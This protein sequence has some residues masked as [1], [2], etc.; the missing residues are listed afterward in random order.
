MRADPPGLAARPGSRRQVFGAALEQWDALFESSKTAPPSTAPILLFYALAQAGRAL[1]AA[2][3]R[4]Q[5]WRP[6]AHGISIG[7]PLLPIGDT[8]VSPV[9]GA[10]TAFALLCVALQGAPLTASTT[11]GRLWA[12]TPRLRSTDGLGATHPAPLELTVV[13]TPDGPSTRAKLE[14]AIV[15]DLPRD[16]AAMLATLEE[17]LAAYRDGVSV[18]QINGAV[19]VNF[20]GAPSLDV[21]WLRTGGAVRPVHELATGD[22]RSDYGAVLVAPA[23]HGLGR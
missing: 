11:L 18:I 23:G 6:N 20:R 19:D 12:A 17:R 16:P 8:P 14:G 1:C 15:A 9:G 22:C 3:V 4:G 21:S 2:G 10:S 5:P 13:R 7:D